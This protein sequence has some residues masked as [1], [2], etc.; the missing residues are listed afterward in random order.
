MSVRQLR[1]APEI[2]AEI[3]AIAEAPMS[4]EAFRAY[5]DTP[6]GPEERAEI[7]ALLDWFNRRYPTPGDRLAYARRVARR[8]RIQVP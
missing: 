7:D 3:R 5:V 4:P 6:M 8:W 1:I 2:A